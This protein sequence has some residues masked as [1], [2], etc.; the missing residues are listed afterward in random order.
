MT[1]R[2]KRDWS[3]V[4]MKMLLIALVFLGAWLVGAVAFGQDI[5]DLS[6]TPA[7]PAQE[8]I[9]SIILAVAGLVTTIIIPWV[10]KMLVDFLRSK[11]RSVVLNS[12]IGAAMH[13]S[14][15][16]ARVAAE[17]YVKA[18]KDARADGKLTQEEI[19]RAQKLARDAALS[20]LGDEGK[21]ALAAAFGGEWGKT[22]DANIE[23]AHARANVPANGVADPQ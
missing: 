17:T 20:A 11:T 23:A 21:K 15:I 19:A 5:T 9:N 12:A 16:G 10:G 8:A 6:G 7:T 18:I 1:T 4:E 22:L 2:A 13:A 14:E 3:W